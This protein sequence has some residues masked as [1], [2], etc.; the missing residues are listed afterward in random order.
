M[1]KN[2]VLI[3]AGGS[4]SRIAGNVPKQFLPV[5]GK[6]VLEHTIETFE[7]HPGVQ[8]IFIVTH[9]EYH[10]RTEEI[11][12]NGGFRKISKVLN[13][14]AVRQESSY[15]GV[16]AANPEEYE[17]VLIHDAARPFV[18]AEIISAIF[19]KLLSFAAVN[20]GVPSP[21]TI[22]EIDVN[23]V[24][25][26]VPER[27]FLRRVQT[28]QGFKLDV[29]R[30]AHQLAVEHHVTNATDD[31]SL[32]LQFGL[33]PVYVVAGNPMNIKITY[34]MDLQVAEEFIRLG[35]KI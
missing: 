22:I 3:L 16:M 25:K 29:I 14:G 19:E 10:Q 11:V 32:I 34:P 30:L 5:A 31:C 26:H 20:V 2:L 9:Q 24:V 8:D 27:K 1:K 35:K 18:T 23:N 12:C 21:D 13:G 4:G 7:A 6:T 17:F 28:P 15:I 33:G